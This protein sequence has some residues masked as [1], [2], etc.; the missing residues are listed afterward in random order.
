[1]VRLAARNTS[2]PMTLCAKAQPFTAPLAARLKITETIIQPALSPMIAE[3][4][5][6]WPTVRRR[7]FIS[8]TTVATICTDA[9]DSAVPR[10]RAVTSRLPGSG[11][12]ESGRNSPSVTPQAKGTRV[13]MSEANS[14]ARPL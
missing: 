2:V 10:N 6:T 4:T 7:K 1:M 12:I 13:P 14:A 11:S 5:M 9:I 3:A 8:R